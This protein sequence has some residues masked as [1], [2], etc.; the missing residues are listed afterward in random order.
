MAPTRA[1]HPP[2]QY[3]DHS[4]WVAMVR[5]RTSQTKYALRNFEN[6]CSGVNGMLYVNQKFLKGAEW[7]QERDKWI[8]EDA[9]HG[10]LSIF[11][12]LYSR[13]WRKL[14]RF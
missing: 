5:V 10:I 8:F 1:S 2:T 7:F 9:Q 6:M 4:V 11:L 13:E 12:I 14:F 3:Y